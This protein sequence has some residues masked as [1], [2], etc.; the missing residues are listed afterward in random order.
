MPEQPL[1]WL[2]VLLKL[3]CCLATLQSAVCLTPNV[4]QSAV[5][6]VSCKQCQIPTYITHLL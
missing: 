2:V 5:T 1:Y 6:I 4:T 3:P